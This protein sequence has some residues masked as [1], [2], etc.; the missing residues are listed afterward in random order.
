MAMTAIRAIRLGVDLIG[1]IIAG[2]V[3]VSEGNAA[4]VGRNTTTLR[5]RELRATTRAPL[6]YRRIGGGGLCACP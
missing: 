5:R 2:F 3:V 4:T 6:V 1:F